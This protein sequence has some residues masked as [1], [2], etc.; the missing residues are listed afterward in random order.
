LKL[1]LF[2]SS[3]RNFLTFSE[4]KKLIFN[5]LSY[6]S[7]QVITYLS[8]LITIP[9]IVR[10]VGKANFG[11]ISMALAL[12]SYMAIISEFGFSIN[13]VQ[14]I[15]Q[16]QNNSIKKREIVTN[17][18]ALQLLLMLGSFILLFIIINSISQFQP[19]R[20]I[21]YFTFLIIP[22]N[23]TM[24]LWFYIGM[25]KIKYLSVIIL[26]S[27]V[28]YIVL[29]FI[30]LIRA[31]DFY[32]VPLFN[33]IAALFAGLCSLYLILFKFKIYP[34]D[35]KS[36]KIIKYIK[37]NWNIF[38]SFLS[39]NLYRNSNVLIL[40]FLVTESSV[41]IYSGGEK[42]V[43]V[44]QSIFA[45]ITQVIYPYI[46]RLRVNDPQKSKKILIALTVFI[47]VGT[48][49]VS[50]LLYVFST[51]I[52]LIV[53]GE[54]FI[55]SGSIIKISSF[56]VFF[57]TLNFILGIIFMTNY[58]MKNEFTKAV[59]LTGILNVIICYLLSYMWQ[60]IGTAFAFLG[61]EI[62]LFLLLLF[63]INRKY[64]DAI[65]NLFYKK[66]SLT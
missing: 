61:A 22:A 25:E 51:K 20:N 4:I 52:A 58:G 64:K 3:F 27:K 37:S 40:G 59:L 60:E 44:L 7:Y 38:L 1:K 36:I 43:I 66:I 18:F 6:G 8:Y 45:P 16:N 49:L 33:G 23:I 29:I 10:V 54:E 65:K 32:F 47:S 35:F 28:L 34:P 13:G 62:I 55:K 21:F 26:I 56:V 63:F 46:S 48:F 50:F 31:E 17:I 42:I 41:G 2:N 9:Y 57:G 11:I 30:F 24:A 14:Y 15:A 12:V 5:F 53:L 19:Y 39:M